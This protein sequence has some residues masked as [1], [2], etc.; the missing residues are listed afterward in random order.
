M[1]FAVSTEMYNRARVRFVLRCGCGVPLPL[2]LSDWFPKFRDNVVTSY[3][4]VEN[5]QEDG[6]CRLICD[7]VAEIR[8]ALSFNFIR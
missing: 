3:S 7:I 4:R 1:C 5:F 8:T 2:S 6:Q